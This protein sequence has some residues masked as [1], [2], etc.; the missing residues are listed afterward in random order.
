MRMLCGLLLCGDCD[1]GNPTFAY[2]QY[3]IMWG[4][5]ADTTYFPCGVAHK[6]RIHQPSYAYSL[7][8]RKNKHQNVTVA[9]Y[10]VFGQ[11]YSGLC[12]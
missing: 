9:G 3:Y 7:R 11:L 10:S 1:D 8:L 5:T 6:I 2:R 4:S 12:Q